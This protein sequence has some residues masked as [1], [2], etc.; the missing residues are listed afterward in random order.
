MR[1]HPGMLKELTFEV[2]ATD[3]PP[4]SL[5]LLA[6]LLRE[7]FPWLAELMSE[8]DREIRDGG[9]DEIGRIY[10]RLQRTIKHLTHGRML[11]ELSGGSKET[12]M[13]AEESPRLL[14]MVVNRIIERTAPRK[15]NDSDETEE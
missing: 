8:A 2:G 3:D 10:H 4:I 14:D 15:A 9:P 13:M 5:L 6:G 12:M 11:L 1:F 7:D